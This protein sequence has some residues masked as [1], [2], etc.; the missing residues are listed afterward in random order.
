MNNALMGKYVAVVNRREQKYVN[1]ILQPYDLG[2]SC[3]KFLLFLSRNEGCNQK[4]LCRDMCVDE[5]VATR[6]MR[7]LQ[8]EG[9]VC[10][11]RTKEDGRSYAL[12]LT[13]KGKGLVPVIRETVRDWWDQVMKNFTEAERETLIR[14]LEQ[15]WR[16]V[17][18]LTEEEKEGESTDGSQRK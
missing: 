5:A 1:E 10:R 11:K 18:E 17:M 3:Y 12:Y 14:L 2:F 15:M 9:Y 6:G 4:K 13:D 7:K 16:N 8:A